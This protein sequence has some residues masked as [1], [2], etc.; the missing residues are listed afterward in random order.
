MNHHLHGTIKFTT[1]PHV[2]GALNKG[3][4]YMCIYYVSDFCHHC[5]HLH[6]TSALLFW[7]CSLRRMGRRTVSGSSPRWNQ[8]KPNVE[9]WQ[10]MCGIE[11]RLM[12]NWHNL[13]WNQDKPGGTETNPTG[14]WYMPCM[15]CKQV[16]CGFWTNAVGIGTSSMWHW[17][18]NSVESSP[19]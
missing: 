9:S 10:A 6:L 1:T 18:K 2:T 5:C 12:K 3:N 19:L 7:N 16:L 15:E 14:N 11:T 13:M 8:G 4:R 17:D